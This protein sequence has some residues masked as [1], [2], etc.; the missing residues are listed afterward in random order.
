MSPQQVRK[1]I[2]T[3]VEELKAIRNKKKFKKTASSAG[4]DNVCHRERTQSN[5]FETLM[6]TDRKVERTV[7][8]S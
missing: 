7:K 6:V 3:N 2:I 5:T 1:A 8:F 4:Q